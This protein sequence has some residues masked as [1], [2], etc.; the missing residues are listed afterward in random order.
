MPRTRIERP[1]AGRQMVGK[2]I[3]DRRTELNLSL[4]EVSAE[5]GIP[6]SVLSRLENA[7]GEQV[8]SPQDWSALSRVLKVGPIELLWL[9]GLLRTDVRE[10]ARLLATNPRRW[11]ELAEYL[12]SQ[13]TYEIFRE[14]TDL[15]YTKAKDLLFK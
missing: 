10:I 11:K 13:Q 14:P 8:I 12:D 4:R 3:R 15:R 2:W 1:S 6:R 9:A 7:Q 5:T